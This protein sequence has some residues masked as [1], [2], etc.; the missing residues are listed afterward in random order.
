MLLKLATLGLALAWDKYL[1][2]PP[3]EAHP[4]VWMGKAA[5]KLMG[6]PTGD[7]RK[8]FTRG[9]AVALAV[10]IA[11]AAAGALV[12]HG[13]RRAGTL[14]ALLGGA[15]LLK[16]TFSVRAMEEHARNIEEPLKRGD[17]EAARRAVSMIVSRDVSGLDAAG[18]ANTAV[19]SVS[20][21]VT[22]S[23]TGP[24]LAYALAGIPGALAYRAVNTLDAM[25]GYHGEY[26]WLGK[27]AARL[28]DAAAY[29]PAR[30]AGATV[31]AAAAA[32]GMNAPAAARTMMEQHG[33][34]PSPNSGWPIAAAAGAMDVEI[35]KVGY[36][37]VGPAGKKV[38]TGDIERSVKLFKGAAVLAALLATAI[39]I[40]THRKQ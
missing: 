8:D 14:P 21:N 5:K 32:N 24:L 30:I 15:F 11:S 33:R 1:G 2:E 39:I 26:E 10:P 19:G 7:P 4:V 37:K 9:L 16:S 29:I 31:V 40:D 17:T 36:Y 20:E 27:A 6:K 25:Y 34:T 38:R 3:A 35:E 28:D 22:D 12:M 18:I 13:L 23:V